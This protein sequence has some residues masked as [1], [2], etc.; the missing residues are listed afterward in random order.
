MQVIF[1]KYFEST[2]WE[3]SNLLYV[4]TNILLL[5]LSLLLLL[6]LNYNNNEKEI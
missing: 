3:L 4:I 2:Y 6:F 5:L 1:Q